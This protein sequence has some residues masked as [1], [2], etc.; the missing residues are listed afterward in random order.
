MKKI[1]ALILGV[2]LAFGLTACGSQ[3]NQGTAGQAEQDSAQPTTKTLVAYYSGTGNTERVA[4]TIAEATG[5]DLFEITPEQPYTSEDLNYRNEDSRVNREHE[6]PSLR[7]VPLATTT[8]ENWSQYETVFIGY[9]I[10]W[11]I[12]AWPV[13]GFAEGN[14]FSGK[15][16]IP[17]ATSASSDMGQSASNLESMAGTGTW[18][19]GQRFASN[20]TD[21]EVQSWVDSLNLDK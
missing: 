8:P 1:A 5:A 18:Q 4:K 14:D 10:W 6:D 3:S 16:V 12:A 13:N 17:F 20:A 15:T 19:E 21:S 2:A 9:P 7:N 11:A